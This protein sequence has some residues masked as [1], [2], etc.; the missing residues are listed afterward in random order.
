[1]RQSGHRNVQRAEER[2]NRRIAEQIEANETKRQ[3]A[4]DE[5]HVQQQ[6][7]ADAQQSDYQTIQSEQ[8]PP[9]SAAQ[10]VQPQ[11]GK[12]KRKAHDAHEEEPAHKS[13]MIPNGDEATPQGG[14]V[15]DT[16]AHENANADTQVHAYVRPAHAP[17]IQG[18]IQTSQL[19]P[20][21]ENL[22]SI[23]VNDEMYINYALRS[24]GIKESNC[25]AFLGS[26]SSIETPRK[27][28]RDGTR[29]K[30]MHSKNS[31]SMEEM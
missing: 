5:N 21:D 30:V 1:M 31:Q 18:T 6:Q 8:Q 29:M 14:V 17:P 9:A 25:E 2:I 26:I 22:S 24:M 20:P 16:G 3:R 23:E 28:K 19:L 4:E 10:H 15:M 13:N 11:E 7:S 27:G 12:G